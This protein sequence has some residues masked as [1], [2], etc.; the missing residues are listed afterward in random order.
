MQTKQAPVESPALG[1]VIYFTLSDLTCS[2]SLIYFEFMF[3][4]IIHLISFSLTVILLFQSVS[5]DVLVLTGWINLIFI[6]ILSE[7]INYSTF[8][9]DSVYVNFSTKKIKLMSIK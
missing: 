9:Y 1:K 6:K 3:I 8:E 2:L 7:M 5:I 4:I